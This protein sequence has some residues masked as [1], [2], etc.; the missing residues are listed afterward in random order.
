MQ[1]GATRVQK[2]F[3]Y[4]SNIFSGVEL[5]G[6]MPCWRS[7]GKHHSNRL[8]CSSSNGRRKNLFDTN[9]RKQK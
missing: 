8:V 5:S 3:G 7:S 2:D 1:S 9:G 6:G 4:A